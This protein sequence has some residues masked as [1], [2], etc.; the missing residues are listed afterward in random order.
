M[1]YSTFRIGFYAATPKSLFD[2]EEKAKRII[3]SKF[4]NNNV[5]G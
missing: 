2:P 3:I 5:K 1:I 4:L